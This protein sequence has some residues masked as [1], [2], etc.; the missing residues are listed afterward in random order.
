[1]NHHFADQLSQINQLEKKVCALGHHLEESVQLSVKMNLRPEE[2]FANWS[3]EQILEKIMAEEEII[4]SFEQEELLE[5]KT[6]IAVSDESREIFRRLARSLHPDL[7]GTLSE[8]EKNFWVKAQKAYAQNDS[9]ELQRI[10]SS[11]KSGTLEAEP[12]SC[13]EMLRQLDDFKKKYRELEAEL[14]CIRSERA[15]NFCS[16]KCLSQLTKE[17]DTEYKAVLRDL[18]GKEEHLQKTLHSWMQPK[19]SKPKARK[20]SH[21]SQESLF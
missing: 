19:E 18:K 11:L 5:T 10:E 13:S 7:R 8:A 20:R 6:K 21:K 15:W 16:K 4:D 2:L 12:L 17:L 3:E 14:R 1:L 9:F